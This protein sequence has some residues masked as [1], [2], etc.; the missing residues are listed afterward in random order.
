MP[1][2]NSVGQDRTY[3]TV[4]EAEKAEKGTYA[5]NIETVNTD[6]RLPTAQM[7][8]GTDPDPFNLGP[9]APGGR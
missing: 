8:K 2:P 3:K 6:D 4:D 1:D 9:Q 7:P 5:D